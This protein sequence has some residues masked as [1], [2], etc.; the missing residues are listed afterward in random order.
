[1][2]KGPKSVA[3]LRRA[4]ALENC[5]ALLGNHELASLRG[6]AER[7]EDHGAAPKYAW[8]DELDPA[9][10][11]WLRRLPF[12]I[13]LPAHDAIVVHAG[14]VPSVS[15]EEQQPLDMVAMRNVVEEAV[16]GGGNGAAGPARRFRACER[17]EPG[18]TAWAPEWRG[19]HVYFGH[20]AKRGL[21]M[22]PRATGLDTGCVYGGS[23][24][25]ALL[26]PGWPPRVVS[27]RAR[28]AYAPKGKGSGSGA[29]P[30]LAC[31][32]LPIALLCH[33]AFLCLSACLLAAA[34]RWLRR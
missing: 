7:A 18:S 10:V 16:E 23:L 20:D 15:L 5:Y 28:S 32:A 31:A 29:Q 33:P 12:T 25:A 8:T 3:A 22:A 19:P 13:S 24:S 27:V 9:E 6:R 17:A 4:R 1:M 11:E 26:E 34:L 30:A 14:L 21:Q 2:N